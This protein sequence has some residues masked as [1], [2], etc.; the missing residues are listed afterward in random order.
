MRTLT[1]TLILSF[2]T[3]LVGAVAQTK[4]RLRF[5]KG[6]EAASPSA[7]TITKNNAEFIVR[8]ANGRDVV[9][10]PR[11][12]LISPAIISSDAKQLADGNWLYVY[13]IKNGEDAQ[14]SIWMADGA[15][16]PGKTRRVEVTS[17]HPP[18]LVTMRFRAPVDMLG[19]LRRVFPLDMTD[20]FRM[21]LAEQQR[22]NAVELR[23]LGPV[24]PRDNGAVR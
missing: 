18:G 7:G 1:T 21:L 3:G 10:F 16:A 5:H 20:E 17:E 4:P 15:L 12:D 6:P 13:V 23:V 9:N 24:P 22:Q 19:E 14:Q 8:S 11:L 2:L